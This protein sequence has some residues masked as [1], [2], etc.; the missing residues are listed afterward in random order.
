MAPPPRL[1]RDLLVFDIEGYPGGVVGGSAP[2]HV[3]PFWQMDVYLSGMTEV[4]TEQGRDRYD[5]PGATVLFPPLTWHTYA[6][7]PGHRRATLK[8]TLTSRLSAAPDRRPLVGS[9]GDP[10]LALLRSA[11]DWLETRTGLR[12]VE[13]SALA[14]MCLAHVLGGASPPTGAPLAPDPFTPQ[15]A[16][17]LEEIAD[18]PYASRSVAAMARQC[19]V[20]A[21]HFA[22]RFRALLGRTPQRYLLE[23]RLQAAATELLADPDLPVKQVAERSGY[24]S[25]HAFTRAFTR[26]LGVPPAAFRRMQGRY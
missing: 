7:E 21:D 13:A 20:T 10:L 6:C 22:R 8:M 12:E 19:A 16:L 9:L 23:A 2:Y 14:E 17:L 24:G 26:V 15:L 18:Q 1:I 25:V 5:W 3:H 4:W 11:E